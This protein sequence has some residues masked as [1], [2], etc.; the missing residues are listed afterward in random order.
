MRVFGSCDKK[1]VGG[2][3][4]DRVFF[5]MA[6][7]VLLCSVTLALCFGPYPGDP[8]YFN[9]V[10]RSLLS[11]RRLYV[12][13]WDCKGPVLYFV[14]AFG[15]FFHPVAGQTVLF[16]VIFLADLVLFYGLVRRSC[17][18]R[19]GLCTFLFAVLALGVGQF[20]CIGRQEML[21]CLIILLGLEFQGR[22]GFWGDVLAGACA[23][24]V[25]FIKPNLITFLSVPLIQ[26]GMTTIRIGKWGQLAR[27]MF[28]LFVGLA[29]MLVAVSVCFLPDA[30]DDLWYGSLFWNITQRRQNGPGWFGFWSTALSNRGFWMKQGWIIPILGSLL[31]FGCARTLVL[32]KREWTCWVVWAILET[33]AA[34][35]F[36]GFYRHYVIVSCLPV[37]LL[38]VGEGQKTATGKCGRYVLPVLAVAV[39]MLCASVG[40]LNGRISTSQ[41]RNREI[42]EMSR[43]IATRQGGV[44]LFGGNKVALVMNRLGRLSGQRF[45]CL[46][47][48]WRLS[49]GDFRKD[50]AEDFL[51]SL[52]SGGEWLISEQPIERVMSTLKDVRISARLSEYRLAYRA[53]RNKVRLYRRCK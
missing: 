44:T 31:V 6:L 42:A 10:G 35:G 49:S 32:R 30:V 27:R 45:P 9:Y 25:F 33:I 13:I 1:P 37:A 16:A 8:E 18:G 12:D 26:E 51:M 2:G 43:M 47:H 34:F 7:A 50:I 52:D 46:K 4:A 28:C 48:W 38:A 24:L 23:G 53:V 11:G 5:S 39:A 22:A 40:F 20:M 17:G 19:A 14:S 3:I 21:A 36:P 29:A 15:A 41:V